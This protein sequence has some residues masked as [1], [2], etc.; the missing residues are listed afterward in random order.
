ME[1]SST[2]SSCFPAEKPGR[3]K[4]DWFTALSR[5][6]P[7]RV[8]IDYND[9]GTVSL[10]RRGVADYTEALE[11]VERLASAISDPP[12]QPT[13]E[14]P[15]PASPMNRSCERSLRCENATS[16]ISNRS[17]G[18]VT[19]AKS[20]TPTSNLRSSC[21]VPGVSCEVIELVTS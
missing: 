15:Q 17:V 7:Q 10:H 20:D 18:E 21:S 19:V 4:F 16:R 9:V 6:Q 2:T 5:A 14:F 11:S 13:K 8:L 1:S 12:R 3:M